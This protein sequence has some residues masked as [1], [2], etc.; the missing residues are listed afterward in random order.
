M[1]LKPRPID[2]ELR[3]LV[4]IYQGNLTKLSN[5]TGRSYQSIVNQL[6]LKRNKPWWTNQKRK[7]KKI[8]ANAR[9]RNAYWSLKNREIRNQLDQM[10]FDKDK[11]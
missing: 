1:S 5:E 3:K 6:G 8:R 7:F 2:L 4:V 10:C 11:Q 9:R